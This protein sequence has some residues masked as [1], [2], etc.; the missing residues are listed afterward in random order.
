MLGVRCCKNWKQ[1]MT[2]GQSFVQRLTGSISE[3]FFPL[4]D[5]HTKAEEFSLPYYLIT[6]RG[7]KVATV[8]VVWEMQTASSSFELVSLCPFLTKVTIILRMPHW[9]IYGCFLL[10]FC[11]LHDYTILNWNDFDVTWLWLNNSPL[12]DPLSKYNHLFQLKKRKW[13]NELD[14]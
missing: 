14:K 3:F 13:E 9:M 11:E 6:D 2:R 8:L 10:I 4:T 7:R 1:D 5:C 12:D